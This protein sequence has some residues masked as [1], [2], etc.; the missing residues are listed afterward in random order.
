MFD[1]SSAYEAN[2]LNSQLDVTTIAHQNTFKAGKKRI[3]GLH[4]GCMLTSPCI[5]QST[6]VL[7]ASD[8]EVFKEPFNFSPQVGSFEVLPSQDVFHSHIL[9][10]TVIENPLY[11]CLFVDLVFPM[12]LLGDFNW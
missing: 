5:K 9:R 1:V 10:Q 11:W 2:K 12:G 6:M 7:F 4:T 3:Q 8:Y